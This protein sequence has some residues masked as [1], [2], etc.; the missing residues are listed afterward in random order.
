MPISKHYDGV[1]PICRCVQ[2][3]NTVLQ[4]LKVVPFEWR[5]SRMSLEGVR[6]GVPRNLTENYA[7]FALSDSRILFEKAIDDLKHLGAEVIDISDMP[8]VSLNEQNIP[9]IKFAGDFIIGIEQY[10]ST[11]DG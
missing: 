11:L 10:L 3:A 7:L 1:G 6:L 9:A 2:D 8:M 5:P 4:A